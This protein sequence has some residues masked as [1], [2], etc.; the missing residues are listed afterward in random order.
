[1]SEKHLEEAIAIVKVVRSNTV[2]VAV[3]EAGAIA[4]EAYGQRVATVIVVLVVAAVATMFLL[5]PRGSIYQI[6]RYLGF[7]QQ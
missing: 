3:A 6:D 4:P 5:I 7:G 1:M 2:L